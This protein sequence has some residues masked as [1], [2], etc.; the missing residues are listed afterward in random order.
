MASASRPVLPSGLT[1]TTGR[2]ADFVFPETFERITKKEIPKH[3]HK[4]MLIS[5][6]SMGFFREDIEL[7]VL[8]PTG[9]LTWTLEIG[10]ESQVTFTGLV[11]AFDGAPHDALS[12]KFKLYE[13]IA[14]LFSLTLDFHP[15]RPFQPRL[16][17]QHQIILGQFSAP[18]FLWH[19]CVFSQNPSRLVK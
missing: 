5:P 9:N 10:E 13:T 7:H 12:L 15:N 8:C 3:P 19:I 18:T 16:R 11:K 6:F 1:L 4:N 17:R 2:S 14:P